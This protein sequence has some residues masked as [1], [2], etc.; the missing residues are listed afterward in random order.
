MLLCRVRLDNPSTGDP[1]YSKAFGTSLFRAHF[2]SFLYSIFSTFIPRLCLISFLLFS[3]TRVRDKSCK[4][5]TFPIAT[6]N[7]TSFFGYVK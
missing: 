3:C 1:N 6:L 2:T 7:G 5:F 4:C